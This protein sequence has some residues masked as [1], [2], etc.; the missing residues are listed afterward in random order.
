[1][2]GTWLAAAVLWCAMVCAA[3]MA[4]SGAALFAAEPATQAAPPRADP[5]SRSLAINEVA[6]MGTQGNVAHEWIELYNPTTATLSL[7]GW[8]L[9]F[10]DGSPSTIA[11][12]GT[13]AAEGY[14]L[15]ESDDDA[16]MT[17]AADL[18]YA[19][20]LHSMSDGG[21]QLVLR[22]D[23]SAV[24]DTASAVG[25]AWPAGVTG[26]LPATMERR[27][28]TGPDTASNWCT[29]DGVTR[30][31]QDA[32]GNL[33]M[34]TPRARNSCYREPSDPGSSLRH[35]PL[36][37][38]GYTPPRYAVLIEAVLYDGVQIGDLPRP[39]RGQ[40]GSGPAQ[41]GHRHP[42]TPDH[43]RRTVPTRPLDQVPPGRVAHRARRRRGQQVGPQDVQRPGP[44]RQATNLPAVDHQRRRRGRQH[45]EGPSGR[46][47]RTRRRARIRRDP[48]RDGCR[49]AGPV[50]CR[51]RTVT[52]ARHSR[53][54]RGWDAGGRRHGGGPSGRGLPAPPP[55]ERPE[56]ARMREV[57]ECTHTN[58]TSGV[59]HETPPEKKRRRLPH[60]TITTP[61]GQRSAAVG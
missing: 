31:G 9:S 39:A 21:E 18:V 58:P 7:S 57:P 23:Q 55:P 14:F 42:H 13:V 24:V 8:T 28:P 30:V 4:V 15:L 49:G 54:D 37:V 27:D 43:P 12:T 20:G 16:V 59:P 45:R 48:R 47:Q 38:R 29:N 11:L 60:Q 32:G 61:V 50:S 10:A 6:W 52:A 35:L 2:R 51:G 19:A 46:V 25:G 3:L 34:G 41:P 1:M 36:V 22:D 56:T 17:V 53:A 26:S 33:I 44:P 5:V 40:A